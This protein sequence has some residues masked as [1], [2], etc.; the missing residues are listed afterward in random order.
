MSSN[1][2]IFAHGRY[3]VII[4]YKISKSYLQ[5]ITGHVRRNLLGRNWLKHLEILVEG[6]NNINFLG[7]VKD[8]SQ[9][10]FLLTLY[11]EKAN[12]FVSNTVRE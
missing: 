10:K 8:E 5:A 4:E 7:N 12:K 2:E 9:L 11:S 6:I 1:A 3:Q